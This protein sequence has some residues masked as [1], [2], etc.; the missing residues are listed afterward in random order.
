LARL[1]VIVLPAEIDRKNAQAKDYF[2][3]IAEQETLF[4]PVTFF[5]LLLHSSSSLATYIS[6]R[7]A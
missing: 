5:V 3:E 1:A 4:P 2:G 7:S 6:D